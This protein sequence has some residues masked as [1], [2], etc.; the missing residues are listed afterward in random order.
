VAEQGGSS[1]IGRTAPT[2]I[3][4][5]GGRLEAALT[6]PPGWL[7]HLVLVAVTLALLWGASAP[8]GGSF[9]RW[10][11]ARA[12]LVA[13]ALAWAGWQIRWRANRRIGVARGSGWLFVIAPV[14][15]VLVLGALYRDLPL[16]ARFGHARP[17]LERVV[18]GAP[19]ATDRGRSAPLAAPETIGTYR[20]QG[21]T[22][23]GDGTFIDVAG[24]RGPFV[25]ASGFAHLPSGPDRSAV[26]AIGGAERVDYEHL[27]GDWY[28]WVASW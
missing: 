28:T 9:L 4:D 26:S 23:I 25:V 7:P 6:R 22:R 18:E 12:L 17:S 8:S 27:E 15:G 24:P 14:C 2:V 13:G 19:A 16:R 11:V 5:G 20:I 1:T 10:L 3:A 21:A